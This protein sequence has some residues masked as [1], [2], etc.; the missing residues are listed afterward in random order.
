[1][2]GNPRI[3]QQIYTYFLTA[4]LLMT[5]HE[6]VCTMELTDTHIKMKGEERRRR[7]RIN[8]AVARRKKRT[9]QIKEWM[10]G[11]NLYN[12]SNTRPPGFPPRHFVEER[13]LEDE[14]YNLGR[15]R[16][17]YQSR[18]D[19][20]R[21]MFIENQ[22][23]KSS[24][25]RRRLADRSVVSRGWTVNERSL[26]TREDSSRNEFTAMG[27]TS[28]VETKEEHDRLETL[29]AKLEDETVQPKLSKENTGQPSSR[30]KVVQFNQVFQTEVHLSREQTKATN[31]QI[32]RTPTLDRLPSIHRERSKSRSLPMASLIPWSKLKSTSIHPGN[33]LPP[34]TSDPRYNR[35]EK[36]LCPVYVSKKYQDVSSVV[37]KLEALHAPPKQVRVSRIQRETR[38]RNFLR[39]KGFLVT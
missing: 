13:K 16:L 38:I 26:L 1:M 5:H 24:A 4:E 14:L 29:V 17:T 30:G 18:Y 32:S 9:H 37:E 20:E 39:E 28:K 11:G 33:R 25:I 31:R 22:K 6:A 27:L 35:L 36:L 10:H 2:Y 8:N 12:I 7:E 19:N 15:K 3:R 34:L 21:I 23:R